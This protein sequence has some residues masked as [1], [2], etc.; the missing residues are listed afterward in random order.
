MLVPSNY[1]HR[2]GDVGPIHSVLS[3]LETWLHDFVAP[4]QPTSKQ[5]PT[6]FTGRLAALVPGARVH[7]TRF[8]GV[9]STNS[10]LLKYV[11]P[12]QPSEPKEPPKANAY[13]MT[14]A[15]HPRAATDPHR[16]LC[17]N[18]TSSDVDHERQ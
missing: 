10:K 3:T 6:E 8:L 9:F 14:W 15:Q 4:D 12:Q 16:T 1:P 7:L 5:C 2:I 17:S 13:F 18:R 11:V